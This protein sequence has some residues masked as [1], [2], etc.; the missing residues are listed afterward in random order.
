MEIYRNHIT[1]QS[2]QEQQQAVPRA[3]AGY[4]VDACNVTGV[5]WLSLPRVTMSKSQALIGQCYLVERPL[6][7]CMHG[8]GH[9]AAQ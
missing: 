2:I 6:L 7:N 1:S 3:L 8:Q 4:Q 9:K 5:V